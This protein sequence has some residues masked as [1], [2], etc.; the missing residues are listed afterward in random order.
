VDTIT[1]LNAAKAARADQVQV[2]ELEAQRAGVQQDLEEKRDKAIDQLATAVAI[3]GVVAQPARDALTKLYQ[4]KT[5]EGS[6]AGL[7]E[8]IAQK[9]SQL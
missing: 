2:D 6:T 3:G 8:L 9:K 5:P 1:S 7:E 4:S